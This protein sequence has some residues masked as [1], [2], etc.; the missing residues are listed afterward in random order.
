MHRVLEKDGVGRRAGPAGMKEAVPT[1]AQ[2][3]DSA[4]E[5]TV[6]SEQP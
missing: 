6:H 2:N 3:H 4:Y 5:V 1:K